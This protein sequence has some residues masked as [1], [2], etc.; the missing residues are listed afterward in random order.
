MK[1]IA[2]GA[3][4]PGSL[5]GRRAMIEAALAALPDKGIEVLRVS[6]LYEAEPYPPSDQ[7]WYINGVAEISTNLSPQGTVAALLD[8]EASLGR[9]RSVKNAARSI[10][11]DLLAYDETVMSGPIELPHPRMHLRNF[12]L[13]PLADLSADWRHPETKSSALEML[14]NL[15]DPGGLRRL[16]D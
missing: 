9:T 14:E 10:D 6:P 13:Q 5:G 4:L 3:N 16:R 15:I 8:V 7:D 11:L 2:F 1:F 12:V